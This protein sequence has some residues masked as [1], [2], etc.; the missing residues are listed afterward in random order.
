M[1]LLSFAANPPD[2]ITTRLNV[3]LRLPTLFG[4]LTRLLS[5]H[6]RQEATLEKLREMCEALEIGRCP[7][8]CQLEP[9]RLIAELTAEL[10]SHFAAEESDAHFA[11]IATQRPEL[12]PRIVDLKTDHAGLLRALERIQLIAADENRWHE[13]AEPVSRLIAVLNAHEEAEAE[14]VQQFVLP[15]EVT[16]ER[17]A[18]RPPESLLA[19]LP[20]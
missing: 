14:L 7:L 5:A 16:P 18:C 19:N 13:L 11:T 2:R 1:E 8:P 20:G 3:E 4:R 10:R 17:L 6:D 15:D 12:L 9:P